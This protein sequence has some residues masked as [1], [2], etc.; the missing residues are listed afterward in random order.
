MTYKLQARSAGGCAAPK[1]RRLCHLWQA[2]RQK[3]PFSFSKKS[4]RG[5]SQKHMQRVFLAGRVPALAGTGGG[6]WLLRWLSVKMSSSECVKS[7]H[8]RKNIGIAAQKRR[9]F[10]GCAERKP[11]GFLGGDLKLPTCMHVDFCR[12]T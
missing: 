6:A 12:A 2:N 1:P 8:K 10:F 9:F 7:L 11:R 3:N 4:R 5:K